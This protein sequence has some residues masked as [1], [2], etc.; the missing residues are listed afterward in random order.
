MTQEVNVS[1]KP[2]R[3]ATKYVVTAVIIVIVIIAIVA[4]IGSQHGNIGTPTVSVNI[5]NINLQISYTGITSGFLG[6]TSQALSYSNSVNGGQQFSLTLTLTSSAL[7]LSHDINSITLNTNGF[8][9]I[10]ISPNLPYSLSPGSSV[11]F[12][13]MIQAPNYNFN[14]PLNILVS[15]S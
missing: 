11:S 9:L 2:K 14:G 5:N 7:L 4:I 6:P 10:S 15:T 1:Q 3:K 13:L 8:T 12:S